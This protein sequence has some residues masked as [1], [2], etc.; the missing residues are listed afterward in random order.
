MNAKTFDSG[1]PIRDLRQRHCD[2][3]L[4]AG[5]VR[6]VNEANGGQ[7]EFTKEC[8][9][10][11]ASIMEFE[12]PIICRFHF[13]VP[14]GKWLRPFVSILANV[15]NHRRMFWVCRFQIIVTDDQIQIA[16]VMLVNSCDCW[17][18]NRIGFE[19]CRFV[20]TCG[21]CSRVTIEVFQKSLH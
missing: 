3:L 19:V 9:N 13:P 11:F 1:R 10:R 16:F 20:K 17:Q 21:D 2:F 14:F 4:R 8:H 12:L 18:R 6:L 5:A 7:I 15:F